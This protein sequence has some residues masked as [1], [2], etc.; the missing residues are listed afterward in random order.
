M[1]GTL[2]LLVGALNR[3]SRPI[4]DPPDRPRLEAVPPDLR[5]DLLADRETLRVV[6]QR[7]AAFRAQLKDRSVAP[8][9]VLPDRSAAL[10][11]CISCG[12]ATPSIRC[13]MCSVACWMALG[14][15]PPLSV[16]DRP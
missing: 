2:T 9:L 13:A 6:L 4:W 14:H 5:G 11:G 8:V 12:G 7:A 1:A 16:V 15:T 3:G 10:T